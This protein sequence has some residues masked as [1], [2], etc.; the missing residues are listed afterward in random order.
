M[1]KV[2]IYC[3]KETPD[4]VIPQVAYNNTSTCFDITCIEDTIVKARGKAIVPNGLNIS[5]DQKDKFFMQVSLR[6]SKGFKEDLIPHY[7]IIDPSYTG[8]LGIKVYNLSDN[9]ILISK[10]ERYA[11]ITVLPI[12]NYE[13]V[14]LDDE[15]FE[16]F[17]K[18]QLRGDNGFGSSGL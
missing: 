11:Q 2:T 10:G 3:H 12:P 4:A 14:E 8:N 9:D 17:K 16:K 6:S 15:K 5:I 7:G 1:N 18:S 13:L